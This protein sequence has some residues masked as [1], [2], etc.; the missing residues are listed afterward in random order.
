MDREPGGLQSIGS[1][2][3]TTERLLTFSVS[4]EVREKEILYYNALMW[5]LRR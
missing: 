5:N 4:S 3:D 2:I 1:Q